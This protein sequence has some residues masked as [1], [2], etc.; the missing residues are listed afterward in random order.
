MA[1]ASKKSKEELEFTIKMNAFRRLLP[2]IQANIE[3]KHSIDD[4]C[5]HSGGVIDSDD[6]LN[7]ATDQVNSIMGVNNVEPVYADDEEDEEDEDVDDI[8][9]SEE[10]HDK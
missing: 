8:D 1:S 10:E 4:D 7:W 3:L 6:I 9:D 5:K 2:I